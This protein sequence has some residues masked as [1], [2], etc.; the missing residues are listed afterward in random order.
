MK[1]FKVG[2]NQASPSGFLKF[3]DRKININKKMNEIF[4]KIEEKYSLNMVQK[5][6]GDIKLLVKRATKAQLEETPLAEVVESNL[7]K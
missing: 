6:F 5:D 2:P 3:T 1:N 7:V 4:N